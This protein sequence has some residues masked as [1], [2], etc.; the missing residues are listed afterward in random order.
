MNNY[1]FP[2]EN[3]LLIKNNFVSELVCFY[4]SDLTIDIKFVYT[5][6][7]V[8]DIFVGNLIVLLLMRMMYVLRK[9]YDPLV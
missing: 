5:C 8:I 9:L 4:F 1:T 7:M 2:S 3:I 6:M